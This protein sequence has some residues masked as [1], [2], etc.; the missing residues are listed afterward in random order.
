MEIPIHML[1]NFLLKFLIFSEIHTKVLLR[2]NQLTV[3]RL[4]FRF[5]FP[6]TVFPE[7]SIKLLKNSYGF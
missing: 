3:L 1:F 6:K 7:T 2:G 5:F 4:Q